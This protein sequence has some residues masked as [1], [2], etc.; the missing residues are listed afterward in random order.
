MTWR[1]K[2]RHTDGR[3]HLHCELNSRR[4]LVLG[5]RYHEIHEYWQAAIVR[6]ARECV[7]LSLF[8]GALRV[9]RRR[10]SAGER[11]KPSVR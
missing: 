10:A 2:G 6:D 3:S 5:P 11:I 1:A 8:A 9:G 4:S 7:E